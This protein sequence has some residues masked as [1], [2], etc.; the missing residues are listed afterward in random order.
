MIH[1]HHYSCSLNKDHVL[2]VLLLCVYEGV[3]Q[4]EN[5]EAQLGC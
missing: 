1:L 3:E 5:V 2:T 4:E